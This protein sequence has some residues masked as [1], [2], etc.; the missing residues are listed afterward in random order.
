MWQRIINK[1]SE[2]VRKEAPAV[3][4]A[5]RGAAPHAAKKFAEE[6]WKRYH[7]GNDGNKEN[8]RKR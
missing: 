2:A 4:S 5:A 1:A 7:R 6:F 3:F 8:R